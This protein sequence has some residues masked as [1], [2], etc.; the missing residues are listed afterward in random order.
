[1]SMS[2]KR[3]NGR[4]CRFE[5]LENRQLAAGIVTAHVTGGTLLVKGDFFGNS[6][7]VAPGANPYEVVVTGV[8]SN[9]GPTTVNGVPNGAITL[10]GVIHGMKIN[11]GVGNNDVAVN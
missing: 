5:S 1:M 3:K 7:T 11:M 4:Q 2:F 9:G 6:I 8:T 10:K